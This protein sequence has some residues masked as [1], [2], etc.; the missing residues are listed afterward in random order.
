MRNLRSGYYLGKKPTRDTPSQLS[1]CSLGHLTLANFQSPDFSSLIRVV[2]KPKTRC[3]FAQ[4]S[5]TLPLHSH[6]FFSRREAGCGGKMNDPLALALFRALLG[7]LKFY[8][9]QLSQFFKSFSLLSMIPFP[10]FLIF[11]SSLFPLN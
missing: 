7:S 3:G 6:S 4:I 2:P 8:G 5:L 9:R 1:H 10:F 11:P